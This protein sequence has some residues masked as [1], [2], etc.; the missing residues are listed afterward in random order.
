MIDDGSFSVQEIIDSAEAYFADK[1]KGRGSGYKQFKRW[2]Y[3]ALRLQNDD[4]YLMSV[5]DQ[6]AELERYDAYLNT[7]AG[8]RAPLNDNWEDL[9][10]FD[11]IQT[12]GWNPGVGRLTGLAIEEGNDDHMIVGANTGGVWRTYD[13]AATWTPL[14]DYFTNLAVYSVAMDPQDADTYFFGSSS[15]LLFKST[16]AGATW[17]LLADVSPGS[18]VINRILIHPTDSNIMFVASSSAGIY[19]STDA[20][21]TWT[22]VVF[23]GGYDVEFKP[24]DP[25][26]VY[27]GSNSV[28]TSTDGGATFTQIQPGLFNG[29]AKMIGVSPDD[30]N[31]V[32]VLDADGSAFGDIY[33]SNDSGTTYASLGHTNRNYFGYDTA[34]FGGNGQAP[35]DMAIAVDPDDVDEV[36]IAGVLMWRSDDGG[37]NFTNTSDW[38]PGLAAGQ[39]KGYHHPDVDDLMF[40]GSTLYVLSDGGIYKADTPGVTQAGMFDDLTP[41]LGIHQFYKIGVSQTADVIV[42][43]GTQ[44]NGTSVYTEALNWRHWLGADGMEGFVSKFNS[45]LLLGTSQFGQMYRSFNQ[46]NTASG[47]NEPG[48]GQGNWVT[49]FEEDPTTNG[50]IYVGYT[51]V[52]K[53]TNNGTSWSAI[54]QNFGSSLDEMKIAPTDNQIIY[55]SAGARLWRTDDG[56]ATNWELVEPNIGGIINN[57]AV[58]PT[59]PNKIA[60]A[61][62]GGF[63]VRISEDGGENWTT[64]NTGLPNFSALAVVWDDNG[65]NGLYLG[66]NYG[67]YYID[68]TLTEWQPYNTNLPNVIVNELEINQ[69]DGK[70]YA[71]TY[72]RGLWASPKLDPTLAVESFIGENGVA[73]FPNPA[74]D[75]VTITMTEDVEADIRIFDLSGKLVIYEPNVDIQNRHS[76]NISNLNQGM[77]FVRLNTTQGSVTKKLLKN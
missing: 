58:H 30:P 46:G 71:G 59:D 49:P 65:A 7:T 74:N 6:I 12:S 32:Y 62:S 50:T 18:A 56:G 42:T 51:S 53:S 24:G 10:P 28:H 11:V 20:G 52:Y 60:C 3:M 54:S 48:P 31:V 44:D 57:F 47:I 36:H 1:D 13:G 34:G 69:E 75:Q 15:G 66:M 68:D 4:G 77:Y 9:G 64:I 67:I 72:G 45:N 19:R 70:I 2:E 29:G 16:D 55:A 21:V 22:E 41:G 61:V 27:A 40:D 63:K 38:Q 73:I 39:N 33:R 76:I 14:G 26:V 43:G 8:N 37:Q 35:R 17:N 5:P 25:S 23:D